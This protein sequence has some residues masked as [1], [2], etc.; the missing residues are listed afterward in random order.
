MVQ[1]EHHKTLNFETTT[2]INRTV[3]IELGEKDP[4]E[5]RELLLQHLPEHP[6]NNETTTQKI[7]HKLK[8]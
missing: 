7:M 5:I 6:D 3:V 1:T 8:F 4:D 2:L